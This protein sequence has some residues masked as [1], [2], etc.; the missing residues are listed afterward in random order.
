MHELIVQPGFVD[1]LSRLS[2]Q[3][4]D[5]FENHRMVFPDL[6]TL[7]V[8]LLGHGGHLRVE[9]CIFRLDLVKLLPVRLVSQLLEDVCGVSG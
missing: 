7:V 2:D 4:P 8:Q 5:S 9:V 6:R 1:S 3:F